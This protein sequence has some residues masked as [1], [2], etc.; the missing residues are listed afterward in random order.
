MRAS[1]EEPIDLLR[2]EKVRRH[3]LSRPPAV[4]RADPPD[5]VR[6][7][8]VV[9]EMPLVEPFERRTEVD[10]RPVLVVCLLDL[11]QDTLEVRPRRIHEG[12]PEEACEGPQVAQVEVLPVDREAERAEMVH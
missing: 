4:L 6:V 8:L 2:S 1:V 7:L 12:P 3:F 5:D 11:R 10:L 9:P